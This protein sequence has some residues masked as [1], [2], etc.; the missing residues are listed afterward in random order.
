MKKYVAA[1]F[2]APFVFINCSSNANQNTAHQNVAATN[3]ETVKTPAVNAAAPNLPPVQSPP[4]T[5]TPLEQLSR[6]AFNSS[7]RPTRTPVGQT[8]SNSNINLVS[9]PAPDDSTFSSTLNQKGQPVEMRV[10]NRDQFLLKV[11]R[12]YVSPEQKI[13]KVYLKSGKIIE[14]KDEQIPNFA[15]ASVSTILNAAGTFK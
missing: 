2:F 4:K 9:R 7:P 8:S 12:I 3:A 11:E 14:L 1:L 13:L 15:V 5:S 6:Q 10:F